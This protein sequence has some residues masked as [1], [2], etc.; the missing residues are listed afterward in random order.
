MIVVTVARRP[1][2]GSVASN[3]LEHGTGPINVDA[4][5]IGTSEDVPA[6][7]AVRRSDYPQS[8]DRTPD[9]EA[10][11]GRS[12]GGLA[13]DEVHWEP[14]GGRWP[15]NLILGHLAGCRQVGDVRVGRGE[16]ARQAVDAGTARH[17]GSESWRLRVG[18]QGAP[19]GYEGGTVAAWEC[20][21]G[22]PVSDVDAPSGTTRGQNP[23]NRTTPKGGAARGELGWNT[24]TDVDYTDQGGASRFFKQVG[25]GS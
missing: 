8:Y 25:G 22:C 1:L 24:G 17:D 19:R 12:R 10:G 15:A 18:V 20:E 21:P 2:A 13:G 6:V 23:A 14:R 4:C 9:G 3:V 11:W 16:G 7:H 5:R